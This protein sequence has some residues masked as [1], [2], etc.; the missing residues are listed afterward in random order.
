MNASSALAV[1]TRI[2]T[3]LVVLPTA[4][5]LAQAVPLDTLQR[6]SP[7]QFSETVP[8]TLPDVS[9]AT[10]DWWGSVQ[11]NLRRAEYQVTRQ[12]GTYLPDLAAAYLPLVL[13]SDP[14]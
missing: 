4:I 5:G 14:P 2:S 8:P 3:T 13:C 9:G 1:L 10:Q 12:E 7:T 11:E 6:Q